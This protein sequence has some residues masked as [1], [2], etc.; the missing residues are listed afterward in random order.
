MLSTN[1]KVISVGDLVS[2]RGD[3]DSTCGLGLVCDIK[4]TLDD[5]YDINHITL[6][7]K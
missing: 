4:D 5:V 3:L 7:G 2:L 1:T 6:E